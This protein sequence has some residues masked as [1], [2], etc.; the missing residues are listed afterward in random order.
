MHHHWLAACNLLYEH[1]KRLWKTSHCAGLNRFIFLFLN[2]VEMS[3]NQ[4]LFTKHSIKIW[5]RA[6][7]LELSSNV[8]RTV[9]FSCPYFRKPGPPGPDPG[10]QVGQ[11]KHRPVWRQPRQGHPFRRGRGGGLRH[12]SGHV[13]SS[14]GRGQTVRDE[15]AGGSQGQEICQFSLSDPMN[16][17]YR[18]HAQ[19]MLHKPNNCNFS[20]AVAFHLFYKVSRLSSYRIGSCC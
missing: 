2:P 14:S 15:R 11:A 9:P 4:K 3:Q 17:T 12:I 18:C 13:S 8:L 1:S 20:P 6:T 5:T 16:H 19:E 7:R 10:P